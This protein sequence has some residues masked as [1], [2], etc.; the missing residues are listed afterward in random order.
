MKD[1]GTRQWVN[2]TG[3]NDTRPEFDPGAFVRSTGTL[4]SLSKR[5]P[6]APAPS[7]SR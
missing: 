1:S 5:A 6:A 2:R 4:Y 7:S 3:E